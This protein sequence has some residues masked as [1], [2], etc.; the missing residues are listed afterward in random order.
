MMSGGGH[1]A[2]LINTCLPLQGSCGPESR[3]RFRCVSVHSFNRVLCPADW[4][5]T[6]QNICTLMRKCEKRVLV[7][8]PNTLACSA[9]PRRKDLLF[10]RPPKM[11][12]VR[13]L[14]LT[15]SSGA[16][17]HSSRITSREHVPGIYNGV[18][19]SVLTIFHG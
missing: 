12:Y 9:E 4:P 14:K 17:P 18:R 2:R 3:I 1:K 7:C 13:K 19:M 15:V 10:S 5:E 11:C 8:R 6:R 16:P